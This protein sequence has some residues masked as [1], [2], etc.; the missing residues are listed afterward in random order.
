MFHG[1]ATGPGDDQAADLKSRLGLKLFIIY[2][3]I[4]AGFVAIGVVRPEWMGLRI[5]WGLNLAIIYGFGLIL[6]AIIMGFLYHLACTRLEE[7][8]NHKEDQP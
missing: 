4:Y 5:V 6:L 3:L 2:A 7:R 8:L 1:P